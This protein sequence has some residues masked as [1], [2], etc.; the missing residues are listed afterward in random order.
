MLSIIN[1]YKVIH[2]LKKLL[3]RLMLPI[4]D[5]SRSSVKAIKMLF[6]LEC[7]S[8]KQ[9]PSGHA[10]KRYRDKYHSTSKN[11]SRYV[12]TFLNYININILIN[13]SYN[14][15]VCPRRNTDIKAKLLEEFRSRTDNQF[16]TFHILNYN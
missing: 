2:I 14:S 3:K 1:R 12:F 15:S 6:T 13:L 10:N 7:R 8:G 16:I 5:F 9:N 4:S 11:D